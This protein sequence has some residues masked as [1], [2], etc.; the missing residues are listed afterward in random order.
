MQESMDLDRNNPKHIQLLAKKFF[1]AGFPNIAQKF[2]ERARTIMT[3]DR[4]HGL[5]VRKTDISED[6]NVIARENLAFDKQQQEEIEKL[7]KQIE[8]LKKDK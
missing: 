5:E 6:V 4:T 8:I 3:E 2:M 1:D 7:K